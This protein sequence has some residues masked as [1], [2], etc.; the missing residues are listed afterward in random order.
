MNKLKVP[1]SKPRPDVNNFLNVIQGKLTPDRPPLIEYLID[2]AVMKPILQNYL[3]RKWIDTSDKTEYMGG[4]M[5]FSHE[6]IERI[7]A[8]LDNLIAFWYYMGYDFIRIEISLPLPGKSLL[9]K[10]TG[11]VEQNRAWQDLESGPIKDW[12]DFEKYPWPSVSEKNFYIHRYICDHL[13]DGM[14]FISC[15]A[16]GVYEHL[17]RLFGYQGLCYKLMDDPSLVSTVANKLGKILESY[18]K[19][20]V[21][22]DRLV[23][24]F[25]GDDL[26][27]NTSTLIS[28]GDIKKYILPWHK[29][30]STMAHDKQKLYFLH[31][32][33][34][35]GSIMEDLISD[36]KIDAKHSFQ[37]KIL[38]ISEAKK[39]YGDR[40]GLLGGVD[41]DK[42][43]RFD[44][45]RLRTYIRDII[46]KCLPGGRFAIGS[47]NSIP[48]YIPINNYLIM[49][50]E[51]LS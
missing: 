44:E 7:N 39:K 43:T 45:K 26:G 37:D 11:A 13:P 14:G 32:C 46:D 50:D 2:N 24:I 12:E 8:W 25:P 5:D 16:G 19:Y 36:V 10:D 34:E 22:L 35:I 49:L 1:L 30:Y 21:D 33:G 18:Y 29:K 41:V 20:L 48:S 9:A 3:N 38:P 27:F 28:P 51:A 15:H 23:A 6:N 17:S 42:L 31:S 4:Q 40:I 47:G